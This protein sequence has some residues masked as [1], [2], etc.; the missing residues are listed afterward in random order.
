MRVCVCSASWLTVLFVCCCCCS[1]VAC[2]LFVVVIDV[3]G[4][5]TN[6]RRKPKRSL[7]SSTARCRMICCTRAMW[8]WM[9][10]SRRCQRSKTTTATTLTH[11]TRFASLLSF[12]EK[13]AVVW[14]HIC[15]V[16]RFVVV[17]VS[18]CCLSL[19]MSNFFFPRLSVYLLRHMK[20]RR[21]LLLSIYINLNKTK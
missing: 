2:L 8:C 20:K 14:S 13:T 9:C 5:T 3:N 19:C 6:R 21:Q 7:K 15:S 12:D 10:G 18:V 1:F 17:C 11:E 4:R 16:S